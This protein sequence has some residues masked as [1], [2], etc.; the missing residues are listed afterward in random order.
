MQAEDFAFKIKADFLGALAHPT[1]LKLIE[2]LRS[3]EQP[4][5][6]LCTRLR[7]PQSSVSKHLAILRQTGLVQTRQQGTTVYY[8]IQDRDIF[9]VLRP[10]SAILR[11]K[12]VQSQ[13]LLSHL[14]GA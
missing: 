5:G 6:A 8:A 3:G 11:K 2:V 9:R 10:V 12:L 1:R 14:S 4:V 7:T 13:E